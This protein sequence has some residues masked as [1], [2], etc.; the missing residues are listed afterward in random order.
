MKHWEDEFNAEHQRRQIVEDIKH[1]RLEN[2]ALRSRLYRPGLFTR[3]MFTFANWMISTGK[4]LRSR[5][6][7]PCVQ[8]KT[9]SFAH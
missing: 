7:I 1:I 9:E 2:V 6:E 4:A 3:G 5:Y 8:N